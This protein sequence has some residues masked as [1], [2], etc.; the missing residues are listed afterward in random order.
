MKFSQSDDQYEN[1]SEKKVKRK[2]EKLA[3]ASFFSVLNTYSTF[4]FSIISSFLI[5]RLIDDIQWSSFT[6]ALSFIQIIVLIL[7]FFPPELTN[8]LYYYI[9]HYHS[10]GMHRELKTFIYRAF[11]IKL[12]FL[13][14]I[15]L[16][17]VIFFNF[18]S[19]IFLTNWTSENVQILI[20]LSPLIIINDINL[21]LNSISIGFNRFKFVL[22]LSIIQYS[23]YISF[24]LY[25]FIFYQ[26]INLISL[27]IAFLIATTIPFIFNIIINVIK[28]RELKVE[29][30]SS[31]KF[32][33]DFQKIIKYGGFVRAGNFFSEILGDLQ[34]IAVNSFE[35]P[36]VM[37]IK[38][39]RD[40][41]SVS[42]NTSNAIANPLIVS[43]T[44]SI[45]TKERGII[46]SIYN[47][48]LKYLIFFIH[49]I[50]GVLFFSI[51]IL[52]FLIYGESRLIY[53]NIVSLY[54]FT[55]VFV[56]ITI[57]LDSLLLADNKTKTFFYLRFGGFCLHLPV[58]LILLIFFGLYEAVLGLNLTNLVVGI[59]YMI[60]TIKSKAIKID[61]KR[62][63]LHYLV[64]FMAI[65]FTFGLEFLFLN[66]LNSLLWSSLNFM[67]ISDFNIFSVL[68]FVL[69][70]FLLIGLFRILTPT[71]IENLQLFLSKEKQIHKIT[72]K[73]LNIFKKI[74]QKLSRND[75]NPPI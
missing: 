73:L 6:V 28:M 34:V 38:I 23:C 55:T 30:K 48:M 19:S 16:I 39:S 41:I 71:D 3:K 56:I 53:S 8:T 26:T 75:S 27:S 45:A 47:T 60:I 33:H 62:I 61:I 13:I 42:K 72:N 15:F 11:T 4:I 46:V 20:I 64:F 21:V 32:K 74:L 63:C 31:F 35:Q 25:H 54:I 70:Y 67:V 37:A 40:F 36:S 29:G 10:L 50:T 22:I 14:P 51:R 9:P 52:I 12:V 66:N 58:F 5:A 69:I 43:F 1:S 65:V 17:S 7:R 2:Y 68:S 24:L 57:P 59:L 18:F 49:I 44:S